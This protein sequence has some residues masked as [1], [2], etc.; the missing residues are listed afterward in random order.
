M[1]NKNPI[2]CGAPILF[3]VRSGIE[4]FDES[5]YTYTQHSSGEANAPEIAAEIPTVK[6]EDGKTDIIPNSTT[7]TNELIVV[8]PQF[9]HRGYKEHGVTKKPPIRWSDKS[10][11]PSHLEA[12]PLGSII[13]VLHNCPLQLFFCMRYTTTPCEST[14]S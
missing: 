9:F 14:R 1:S 12:A 3:S 10:L 6:F 4:V 8:I 13:G 7:E 2:S 11:D 5:P